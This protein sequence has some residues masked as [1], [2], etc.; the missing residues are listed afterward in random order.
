MNR[1]VPTLPT[2][3]NDL[4][5]TA[6]QAPADVDQTTYLAANLIWSPLE[7]V[8]VGVEYLHG[9]RQNVNGAMGAAHR[10]QASVIFD[11]P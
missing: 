8:K 3:K 6:F 11:L 2:R 7:R 9:T 1:S 10:L 4:G 5:T